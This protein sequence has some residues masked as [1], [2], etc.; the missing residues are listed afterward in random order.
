MHEKASNDG[1]L[2]SFETILAPTFKLAIWATTMI[3]SIWVNICIE[4]LQKEFPQAFSFQ[5]AILP[6]IVTHS[7]FVLRNVCI[8]IIKCSTGGVPILVCSSCLLKMFTTG[9]WWS[10]MN[11]TRILEMSTPI[12]IVTVANMSLTLEMGKVISVKIWSSVAF[13]CG[14]WNWANRLFSASASAVEG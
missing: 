7:R 8:V 6:D 14:A 11:D 9:M 1:S 2:H 5:M 13:G 12:P 10:Y 3:Y 4:T